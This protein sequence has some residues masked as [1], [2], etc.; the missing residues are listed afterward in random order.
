MFSLYLRN[1]VKEQDK[2]K[3]KNIEKYL[4]IQRSPC[5]STMIERVF[6]IGCW[7]RCNTLRNYGMGYLY[8]DILQ[9]HW[10]PTEN[11]RIW[12]GVLW[13]QIPPAL[14]GSFV[15]VKIPLAE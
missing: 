9:L 10:N 2:W 4:I 8:F 7:N 1:E 15:N 11:N 12:D 6:W 5:I 3:G 13:V 14:L